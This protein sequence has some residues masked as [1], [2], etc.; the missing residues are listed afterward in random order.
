LFL[1]LPSAKRF[2]TCF[3]LAVLLTAVEGGMGLPRKQLEKLAGKLQHAS[4]VVPGGKLRL[5]EIYDCLADA[6]GD[7]S[8]VL[9]DA[10]L[11]SLRWWMDALSEPA[12]LSARLLLMAPQ[13]GQLGLTTLS[14]A[15]VSRRL[16]CI[17]SRASDA[18]NLSHSSPPT[19]TRW[20]GT[21]SPRQGRPVVPLDTRGGAVRHWG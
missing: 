13:G 5:G 15:S 19:G 9:L 3:L 16:R 1:C 2:N 8:P 4:F 18:P 21:P 12:A 11:S 14:D 20:C 10:A 17:P 6:E 7:D